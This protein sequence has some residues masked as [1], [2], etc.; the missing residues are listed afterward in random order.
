M[1]GFW[2]C[3]GSGQREQWKALTSMKRRERVHHSRDPCMRHPRSLPWPFWFFLTTLFVTQTPSHVSAVP[4]T[5]EGFTSLY[6]P[7][8]FL[9]QHS[10]FT[11]RIS[12]LTHLSRSSWR[13]SEG[14]MLG[15]GL[16]RSTYMIVQILEYH[17]K[18]T[19]FYSIIII[20]IMV[21]SKYE[22]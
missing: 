7:F 18:K 11:N 17:T 12:F 4:C 15:L 9:V 1:K 22:K 14:H 2:S 21:R 16:Q 3:F 5:R 20:I 6:T 8:L 19:L 13:Q 10:A